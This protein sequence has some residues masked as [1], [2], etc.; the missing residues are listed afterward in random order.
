MPQGDA[1]LI[2]KLSEKTGSNVVIG[3][4]ATQLLNAVFY[5]LYKIGHR[6]ICMP[7]PFWIL[8]PGII[9]A[10]HMHWTTTDSSDSEEADCFLLTSPNNPDGNTLS[11]EELDMVNQMAI[12]EKTTLI[13][14]A[15]YHNPIYIK[16]CQYSQCG[17][18][19][20]YSISKMY[21]L[22]GLRI[23]FATIQD[24]KMLQYIN[25]YLE[26]NSMGTSRPSQHILWKLLNHFDAN[27]GLEQKF[28]DTVRKKLEKN[29]QTL[30]KR[31]SKEVLDFSNTEEQRGMF[32]WVK[33]GPKFNIDKIK[34]RVID[35]SY[36]GMPGYY[37]V[38]IAI[39]AKDLDKAIKNLNS[40]IK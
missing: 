13:H 40:S 21:G 2:K 14:D 27:P 37:R 23:G 4:G 25:Q 17:V 28:F 19:Q 18:I 5:A 30:I 22:S 3:T 6:K 33:P 32:L 9:D 7:R 24:D 8:T 36:F 29:K 11:D 12:E 35:G 26:I 16:C 34:C 39:P 1:N 10:S 31:V 38:S 15:A 20:L